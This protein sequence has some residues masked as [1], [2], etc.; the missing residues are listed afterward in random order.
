MAYDNVVQSQSIGQFFDLADMFLISGQAMDGHIKSIDMTDVSKANPV[1]TK[2]PAVDLDYLRARDG[3]DNLVPGPMKDIFSILA[4]YWDSKGSMGIQPGLVASLWRRGMSASDIVRSIRASTGKD[5]QLIKA[6]GRGHDIMHSVIETYLLCNGLPTDAE[7][8][9]AEMGDLVERW[10][11]ATRSVS[12]KSADASNSVLHWSDYRRLG[13]VDQA[14]AAL[15]D[16]VRQVA[17]QVFVHDAITF[18]ELSAW[19]D[20]NLPPTQK[21]SDR[22]TAARA[23]LKKKRKQGK[24]NRKRGRR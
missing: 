22:S 19:V 17:L 15:L 5:G 6:T 16:Q 9:Q 14:G 10:L 13:L 12:L 23:K 1:K 18:A 2:L 20:E 7:I 21:T 8:P 24:L 4:A 3:A 11:T